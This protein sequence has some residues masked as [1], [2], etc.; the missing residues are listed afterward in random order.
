MCPLRLRSSPLHHIPCR[1]L[2]WFLLPSSM[3]KFDERK[4]FV[5][6]SFVRLFWSGEGGS[7]VSF[8]LKLK[9]RSDATRG[10]R[11]KL[12]ITHSMFQ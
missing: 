9:V 8:R 5:I 1:N 10:F 6:L 12:R 3:R 2:Y 11:D 7:F 4:N